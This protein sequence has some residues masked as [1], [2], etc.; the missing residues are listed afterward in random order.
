MEKAY[1]L[2][3]LGKKL[4]DAGLPVLE[5]VAEKVLENVVAWLK[6]SA[7]LSKTPYDDMALVVLPLIEEKIKKEINKI[8]KIEG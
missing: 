8:N 3:D 4:S 6:E 1:D 5:D 2:K 7:A